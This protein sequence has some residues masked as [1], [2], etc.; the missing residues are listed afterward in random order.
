MQHHDAEA[1]TALEQAIEW[2]RKCP[3]CG[4]DIRL[5]LMNNLG[6]LYGKQGQHKKAVFAEAAALLKD[7]NDADG[8]VTVAL[9]SNLAIEYS[10]RHDYR[11]AIPQFAEAT[12]RMEKG[13]PVPP[14]VAL[15]ILAKYRKC[16]QNASTR[17][18]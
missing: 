3:T 12:A 4:L 13:A 1:A 7:Y 10:E 14:G 9:L 11:A 17:E 18:E 2:N 15:Q 5:Q 8:A 6:G 16:V